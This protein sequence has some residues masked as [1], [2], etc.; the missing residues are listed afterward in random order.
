MAT[1]FSRL[2]RRVAMA[3]GLARQTA[4]T[5]ETKATPTLQVAL[6]GGEIRS[7]VPLMQLY[8][9][10]SRPVPGSD[11][12]VAFLSGDRT[13]GVAVAAGDQRGRPTDLQPGEVTV[14]HPRTGSR[15]DLK[16][17]GSVAISPANKKL[18]IAADIAVSGK[19]TAT[20]DVV[21]NGV[22]LDTHKH[23]GVKSGSDTSGAPVS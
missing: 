10:A 21:A 15:I 16:A 8:G 19:I 23:S 14:Y 11:I 3:F 6:P 9:F 2:A 5:D 13:R 4:D 18:T 7:D 22:S 20:G 1:P 12:V 17:D